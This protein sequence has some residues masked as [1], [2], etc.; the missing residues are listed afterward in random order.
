MKSAVAAQVR[1]AVKIRQLAA[2]ARII[3]PGMKPYGE[4]YDQG[5]ALEAAV[6]GEAEEMTVLLIGRC[7]ATLVALRATSTGDPFEAAVVADGRA[8]LNRLANL[9]RCNDPDPLDP[10]A[11]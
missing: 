3:D 5:R 6:R 8:A 7:R 1:Y 4:L 2:A 10:P 11:T 9:I